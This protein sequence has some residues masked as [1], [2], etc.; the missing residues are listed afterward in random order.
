MILKVKLNN[1]L[2]QFLSKGREK[3]NSLVTGRKQ[4]GCPLEAQGRYVVCLGVP[5]LCLESR[6]ANHYT[7]EPHV[8]Q[9]VQ[10]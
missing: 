1:T 2:N 10:L 9:T 7:V 5:G 3:K 8:L 6:C 4:L